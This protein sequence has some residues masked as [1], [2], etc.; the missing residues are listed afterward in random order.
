[1]VFGTKPLNQQAKT[2]LS[3]MV[4]I[5][6][7]GKNDWNK[8]SVLFM[9]LQSIQTGHVGYSSTIYYNFGHLKSG[10]TFLDYNFQFGL[11]AFIKDDFFFVLLKYF[12]SLVKCLKLLR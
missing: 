3:A 10:T 6:C 2:R 9:C 12:P 1:M 11:S 5:Y 7:A 4:H 8:Q